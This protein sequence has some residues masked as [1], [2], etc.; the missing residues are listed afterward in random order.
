MIHFGLVSVSREKAAA[1]LG[2]LC[3]HGMLLIG[4]NAVLVRPAEYGVEEGASGLE[5]DLVA[6]PVQETSVSHPAEEPAADEPVEEVVAVKEETPG[7]DSTTFSSSGG[8][9]TE[10]E[11]GYLKNPAP[12]YP[13]QARQMGQEGVV[14]L[15]AHVSA[16]GAPTQVR[17]K[18]S[19]GF[20]LLDEAALNAVR[21]WKFQPA[22]VGPLAIDCT[23]EIPVRFQ[24]EK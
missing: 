18:Q 12:R 19:S 15:W 20:E 6:A 7:Y 4:G 23:V 16:S 14:L 24:L 9:D 3:L 22:R 17:I 10:A 8:A 21:K 1:F 11:P 2:A 13:E 5:I